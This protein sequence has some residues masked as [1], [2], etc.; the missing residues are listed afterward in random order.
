MLKALQRV[1]R[2]EGGSGGLHCERLQLSSSRP[3]I[4]SIGIGASGI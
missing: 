1:R 3:R 2:K 4:I